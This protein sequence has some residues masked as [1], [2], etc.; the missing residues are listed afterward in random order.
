[1][2]KNTLTQLRPNIGHVERG[3]LNYRVLC[4]RHL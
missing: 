3:K 1:M 4:E 2:E